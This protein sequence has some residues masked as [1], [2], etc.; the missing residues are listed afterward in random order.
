MLRAAYPEIG[1][2]PL[3]AVGEEKTTTP[4]TVLVQGRANFLKPF[5]SKLDSSK[6]VLWCKRKNSSKLDLAGF[7]LGDE[8]T[9]ASVGGASDSNWTCWVNFEHRGPAD[10]AKYNGVQRRVRHF[11]NTATKV[12]R[13]GSSPSEEPVEGLDSDKVVWLDSITVHFKGLYPQNKQKVQVLCR[14]VFTPTKWVR[15]FLTADELIDF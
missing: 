8:C 3:E 6:Q 15:R 12:Q 1:W 4:T 2:G 11:I 5:L 14:S 13:S 9:H 10:K 7:H